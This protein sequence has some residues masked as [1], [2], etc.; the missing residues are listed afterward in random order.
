MA[1]ASAKLIDANHFTKY[2]FREHA[3]L[4]GQLPRLFIERTGQAKMVP[5]QCALLG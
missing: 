1:A 3:E 4:V 2:Q 5:L